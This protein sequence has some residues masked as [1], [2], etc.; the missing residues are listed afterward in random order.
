[1][2]DITGRYNYLGLLSFSIC[3][4]A[5]SAS[6]ALGLV[7]YKSKINGYLPFQY[8][9]KLY[10]SHVGPTIDKLWGASK[11]TCIR[12]VQNQACRFYMG[13]GNYTLVKVIWGGRTVQIN[14]PIM[15]QI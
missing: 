1:M 5:K 11:Q 14:R 15:G 8:F 2:L 7:I 13:F 9:T 3:A 6:R 4:V 12:T 10:D